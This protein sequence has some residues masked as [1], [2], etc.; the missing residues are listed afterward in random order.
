MRQVDNLMCRFSSIAA[1]LY[2]IM[3]EHITHCESNDVYGISMYTMLYHISFLLHHE[4][5]QPAFV[6]HHTLWLLPQ[7]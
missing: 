1:R 6:D 5:I 3:N 7:L 2:S 4:L